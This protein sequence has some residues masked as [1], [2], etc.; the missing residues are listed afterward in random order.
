MKKSIQLFSI[1]LIIT[2]FSF[3]QTFCP[4]AYVDAY[5]FDEEVFLSWVQTNDFDDILFDEC[6]PVCS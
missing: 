1:G 5:F 2:S 6:F 3:G 4:P